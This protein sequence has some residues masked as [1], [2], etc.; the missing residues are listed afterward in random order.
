MLFIIIL[1]YPLRCPSCTLYPHFNLLFPTPSNSLSI[2]LSASLIYPTV[3]QS[4]LIYFTA[5]SHFIQL[6]P[7][8]PYR[9][10]IYSTS[11]FPTLCYCVSPLHLLVPQFT[12]FILFHPTLPYGPLS[13]LMPSSMPYSVAL[14]TY[15]TSPHSMLLFILHFID[16]HSTLCTFHKP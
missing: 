15:P 6:C 16:C 10:L 4:V 13:T 2:Y 3:P 7:P 14:Y 8:L 12:D 1:S 11:L 5:A 9:H